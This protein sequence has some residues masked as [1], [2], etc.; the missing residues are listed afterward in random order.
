MSVELVQALTQFGPAG[1]IGVL[2]LLERRAA[3]TRERQLD[4]AHREL[5]H[6]QTRGAELTRLVQEHTAALAGLQEAQRR[7]ADLLL[8]LDDERWTKYR[9]SADEG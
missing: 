8:R 6:E 1:L 9:Q 4:E 5:C 3:T 2:W 7:M